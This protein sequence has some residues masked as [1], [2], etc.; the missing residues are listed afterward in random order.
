MGDLFESL[1][2]EVYG[3]IDG[4]WG[5]VKK[6]HYC[7]GTEGNCHGFTF[8]GSDDMEL[9]VDGEVLEEFMY[10]KMISDQLSANA[11]P[12]DDAIR[13]V[14]FMR[15]D[16]VMHS[17]RCCNHGW[18]HKWKNTNVIAIVSPE[19]AIF[20]KYQKLYFD[21]YKNTD[22]VSKVPALVP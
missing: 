8:Y 15:G 6:I 17:A 18:A 16:K 11:P 7:T 4:G 13:I 3:E 1:M 12:S 21:L 10:K 19:N 2:L 22:T 9:Y 5:A 20:K 14:V